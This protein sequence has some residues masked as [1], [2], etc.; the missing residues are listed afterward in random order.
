MYRILDLT[1]SVQVRSDIQK[2]FSLVGYGPTILN[3][4]GPGFG[5]NFWDRLQLLTI[6]MRTI[7]MR[8]FPVIT[9][10]TSMLATDSGVGA[11]FKMLV[12]DH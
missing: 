12:T 8:T 10:A 1:D 6:L 5:F 3:S 9:A 4:T 7:L 2:S 11:N